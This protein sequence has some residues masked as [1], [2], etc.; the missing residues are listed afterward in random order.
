[1]WAQEVI[2]AAWAPALL[3]ELP[4]WEAVLEGG[5]SLVPGAVLD[6][7]HDNSSSAGHMQIELSASVTS[8]LLTVVP[9]AFHAEIND[10][11]LGA[12]AVAIGGWRIQRGH[13]VGG[14]VLID[15]EG[16][17]REPMSE[18]V[19]LSRT[20][21]WFTSIFPVALDVGPIDFDEAWAGGSSMGHA[22]K[23]IKEQLRAVPGKGLG[24]GLLRYLHPESKTRLA[25]RCE[26]QMASTIWGA[27]LLRSLGSGH[28]RQ[29]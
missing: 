16:H 17:G 7:T 21:G 23:R 8:S 13:E 11:L 5:T 14:P 6:P 26:P 20:V 25:Q 22:I 28:S 15:L 10:V 12:L 27:S 9:A 24:Y 3:A 4:A 29:R 1:M 2:E 19:D 18:G